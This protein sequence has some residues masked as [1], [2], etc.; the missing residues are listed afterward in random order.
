MTL[1]ASLESRARKE[2]PGYEAEAGVYRGVCLCS[3][4]EGVCVTTIFN[5]EWCP[6]GRIMSVLERRSS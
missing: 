4:K 1:C 6:S 5:L 2:A 3:S